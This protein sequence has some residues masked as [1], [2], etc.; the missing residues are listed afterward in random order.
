MALAIGLAV[1]P[2]AI[3]QTASAEHPSPSTPPG[4]RALSGTHLT[5]ITD[6][7]PSQAVDD[8]P[9]AFDQAV[10]QWCA[11]FNVS[12][13]AVASWR[14]QGYLMSQRERF[15]RA[16]WLPDDLPPFPHGF[17]RGD[18][19]WVAE[20]PSDYYRRHLLL[21]EGTHAFMVRW[22]GG[23]GPAWYR[24][25]MA[26]LLATHRFQDGRLTL[27]VMPQTKEEVP[28]WGRI[29]LVRQAVDSGKPRS[30]DDVL[31]MVPRQF[32]DV[33]A[34]AWSWAVTTFLH[35]HPQWRDRV[36]ALVD[37]AGW[38]TARFAHQWTTDLAAD[39]AA[40]DDSWAL[41]LHHLDYGYDVAE[42]QIIERPMRPWQRQATVEVDAGRGWQSTGLRLDA[43][44]RYQLTADGRIQIKAQTPTWFSE[45]GGITIR[46]HDGRPLG[47][48]LAAVRPESGPDRPQA[49]LDPHAVGLRSIWEPARS[50]ILYLR[51]N[52]PAGQL[53]DNRG[54]LHVQV[55]VASDRPDPTGPRPD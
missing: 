13:P 28:E 29:L 22:L 1:G 18:E 9:A 55:Q 14:V 23:T 21:H 30:F 50:G 19:F 51:I 46:Y 12:R 44:R 38:D 31:A 36:R 5:L 26:E 4:F 7:P 43:G 53:A 25:G 2:I 52:E 3:G 24:E 32:A 48:L 20:Q 41:F 49:L 6:L 42:D 10:D 34:Y 15:R 37:R 17:Q 16:G 54:K 8:L 45:A 33:E 40:L 27:A 11:F 39:R 47:M 35:G